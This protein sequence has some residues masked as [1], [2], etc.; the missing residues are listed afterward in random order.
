MLKRNVCSLLHASC[1]S[2]QSGYPTSRRFRSHSHSPHACASANRP[3]YRRKHGVVAGA[4]SRF[5]V[6][7]R[8]VSLLHCLDDYLAAGALNSRECLST[9]SSI[10]SLPW[11]FRWP[12]CKSN[13]SPQHSYLPP[14]RRT[15]HSP[16]CRP[17]SPAE[18]VPPCHSLLWRPQNFRSPAR[19][20]AGECK[21]PGTRSSILPLT[22]L[23]YGLPYYL[24]QRLQFVMNAAAKL[25]T[26]TITH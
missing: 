20:F 24:I 12:W 18:D 19:Y 8:R 3:S 26:R 9:L 21:V 14:R 17:H 15:W 22:S 25:I 5:L 4:F 11:G 23:L 16:S 7:P 13:L 6:V 10:M 2:P 1:L